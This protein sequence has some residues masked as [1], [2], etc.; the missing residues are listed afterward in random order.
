MT[1][2]GRTPARCIMVQGTSSSCGKSVV[3]AALCRIFAQDGWRV[4]PFKS[5]NMSS[6]S[7][8]TA[9]GGE[10]GTAQ[11]LQAW[12]A[13]I[14]P[15]SDMNPILLKPAGD[16][17][18]QV[19]LGGRPLRRMSAEEYHLRKPEL[20][21][22]ALQALGRLRAASDIVVVEGA[23]SPAEINLAEQDIANMRIARAA[24]AAVVLVGDIDRGGM[25]A[26]LVGT[27]ELLRQEERDLVA[28]FIVNKFRGTPRL[29]RP[30]LD[31][32]EERTGK[33]VLGVVPHVRHLGLEEEDGAGPQ[34][35]RASPS[36]PA[37][38]GDERERERRLDRLAAVVRSS[39]DIPRIYSLLAPLP[40]PPPPAR[41][42]YH[43][44]MTGA[45]GCPD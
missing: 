7:W 40:W 14:E 29:L 6:R 17:A 30:G 2:R 18:A 43:G 12:A 10:M 45:C 11:A 24:G 32:I 25:F 20:L 9:Q 37:A 33:P 19:V 5:Q 31:F 3:T 27:L 28:G 13:G 36:V 4:A 23:G 22:A 15:H 38:E 34:E 8:V 41:L 42:L 1:V 26:S 35:R 16:E 44:G 39:L 21:P